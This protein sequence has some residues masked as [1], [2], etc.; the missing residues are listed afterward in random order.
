MFIY[1][2]IYRYVHTRVILRFLFCYLMEKECGYYKRVDVHCLHNK[3]KQNKKNDA[4]VHTYRTL[5]SYHYLFLLLR[6]ISIDLDIVDVSTAE[7]K[8]DIIPSVAIGMEHTP[9]PTIT[10]TPSNVDISTTIDSHSIEN[11]NWYD[12]GS[13]ETSIH[14]TAPIQTPSSEIREISNDEILREVDINAVG[15][16]FFLFSPHDT[17]DNAASNSLDNTNKQ[18]ETNESPTQTSKRIFTMEDKTSNNIHDFHFSSSNDPF[19]FDDNNNNSSV[20]IT[21][22]DDIIIDDDEN[23]YL[24]TNY[25]RPIQEDILYEVEHE[26]SFSDHSQNTSSIIPTDD[27]VNL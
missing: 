27:K 13:I 23:H 12:D 18:I 5:F 25:R 2:Y 14:Q 6:S 19:G 26:N 11:T 10:S 3:K 21:N 4:R 9:L 1:I 16:E 24:N 20:M 15:D 7:Q 8:S 22:L 17:P